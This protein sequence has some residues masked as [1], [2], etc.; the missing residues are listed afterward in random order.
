MYSMCGSWTL[1]AVWSMYGSLESDLVLQY[2]NV[3]GVQ[4]S[5]KINITIVL[6]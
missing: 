2:G 6:P 3:I 5:A 4:Y 1:L